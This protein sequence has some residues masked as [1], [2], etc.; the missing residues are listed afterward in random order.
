ML[1]TYLLKQNLGIIMFVSFSSLILKLS[2]TCGV[3]GH[4][5]LSVSPISCLLGID[6]SLHD[7]PWVT[8]GRSKQL[9]IR[10]ERD[11][12]TKEEQSRNNSEALGQGPGSTLQDTQNNVFVPLNSKKPQQ[13]KSVSILH[14]RLKEPEKFI[15]RRPPG[16]RLKE[17][18]P[19]THPNLI[20]SSTLEPLL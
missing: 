9:L 7:L 10:E 5:N 19:C 1:A 2:G 16:T 3:P 20:S 14:S 15:K 17:C 11:V 13:M 4:G 8:K 18:S 6:S 12:E